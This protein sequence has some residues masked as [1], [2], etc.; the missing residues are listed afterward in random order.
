MT[1]IV[2]DENFDDLP[3]EISDDSNDMENEIIPIG[4]DEDTSNLVIE[5]ED[6][7]L[8]MEDEVEEDELTI[9]EDV[10]A[11]ESNSS[12]EDIVLSKHTIQGKHSL[13]YDSIFKGKKEE[14]SDEY[15][16]DIESM[17]FNDNFEVDKSSNYW[18]ESMDNE[19][20]VKEKRVKEKVYLVL[21]TH[22]DISFMNNRRKPS[23]SDFNK[24]YYLLKT[25]LKM[26]DLVMLKYL[27]SYR[28]IFLTI[29]LICLNY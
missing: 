9:E 26:K 14:A 2:K 6:D 17:Y 22:T 28:F 7:D 10:V 5:I 29:Y 16:I 20:Y 18:Y 23:R 27:M 4:D 19:N 8:V 13:K 1:E 12:D 15:D 3:E 11:D 25:H 24:N 21:S